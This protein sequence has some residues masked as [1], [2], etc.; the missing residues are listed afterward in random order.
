M[1]VLGSSLWLL[2][3]SL[4]SKEKGKFPEKFPESHRKGIIVSQDSS[5]NNPERRIKYTAE[6]RIY[7]IR[8]IVS[9]KV[10]IREIRENT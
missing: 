1:E 2:M 3:V 5:R 8:K 7:N 10:P 4:R 9:I 6:I